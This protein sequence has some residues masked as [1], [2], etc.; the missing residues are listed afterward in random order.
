MNIEEI[1]AK[2]EEAEAIF[3]QHGRQALTDGFN[4][5]FERFPTLEYFSWKQYAPYFNDGEPCVFSVY[6]DYPRVKF[7]DREE[8]IEWEWDY[9]HEDITADQR[10]AEKAIKGLL[11]ALPERIMEQIFG[12]DSRIAVTRGSTDAIIEVSEYCDH[13]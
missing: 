11:S 12:S 10:A 13:D 3:R 4:Q 5:L 9:A 2:A 6:C 1:K 8:P 7:S